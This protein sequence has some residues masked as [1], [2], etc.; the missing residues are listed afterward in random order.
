MITRIAHAPRLLLLGALL[1]VAGRA[2]AQAREA[3]SEKSPPSAP[4]DQA[5]TIGECANYIGS[6]AERMMTA[7]RD[8][9]RKFNYADLIR[10]ERELAQQCA[11]RFRT[12]I[13]EGD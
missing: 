11:A 5:R 2:G 13:V 4:P 7:A 10:T 3:P 6:T 12:R 8:A 1:I 9:K